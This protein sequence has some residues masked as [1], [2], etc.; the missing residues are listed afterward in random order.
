MASRHGSGR[1]LT[2][3]AQFDAVF[4]RGTRLKG[5]LFLLIVAWN[6]RRS[7]RLGLAVSRRVGGAVERNRA[8]RLVRDSFRRL[9]RGVARGL[10]VVVVAREELARARQ[11]DVDREL[12]GRLRRFRRPGA[13]AAG[14]AAPAA[15]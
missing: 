15:D 9:P 8:K 3:A 2:A 10:D 4:A 12:H 13:P 11:A 6:S 5:P 14:A 7:D 1:R